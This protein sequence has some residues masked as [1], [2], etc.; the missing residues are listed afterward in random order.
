MHHQTSTFHP[1]P[2][3]EKILSRIEIQK[4]RVA[5]PVSYLLYIMPIAERFGDQVYEVA[6]RSLKE[7]GVAVTAEQLKAVAEELKTPEGRV[8]Y[9]RDRWEH[10]WSI[11]PIRQQGEPW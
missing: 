7:S 10:I 11:T 4:R 9:E 5:G 8:R 3:K 2:P 1:L 6:A